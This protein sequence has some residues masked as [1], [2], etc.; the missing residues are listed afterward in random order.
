MTD[1]ACSW[2]GELNGTQGAYCRGKCKTAAS[3]AR[4]LN[5]AELGQAL[6]DTRR[7]LHGLGV[8]AARRVRMARQ[9]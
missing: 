3:R 1:S 7:K 4:R 6:L 5:L 2:C 9:E 8:E